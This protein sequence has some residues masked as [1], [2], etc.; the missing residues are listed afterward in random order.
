M[1]FVIVGCLVGDRCC[2]LVV[3]VRGIIGA[4]VCR[5][6]CCFWYW[7]F[8]VELVVLRCRVPVRAVC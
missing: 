8:L 3:V 7:L 2:C 5:I 4:V 6:V 1:V